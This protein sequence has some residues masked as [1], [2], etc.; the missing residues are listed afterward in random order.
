MTSRGNVTKRV[1]KVAMSVL[2][3]SMAA[4]TPSDFLHRL[5]TPERDARARRVLGMVVAGQVDS[6]IPRAQ[7]ETDSSQTAHAFFQLDSALRG[8]KVDSLTL[9]GATRF[10][11]GGAERLTLSYE[12]RTEKGWLAAGITTRDSAGTWALLGL[13]LNPLPGELRRVNDFNLAGSSPVRYLA[14]VLMA[15]CTIFTVGVAIFLATRRNF[16]KRWRWVLASLFGVGAVYVN[17]TTGEVAAKIFALQLFGAGVVRP[18]E[19][20]PWVVSFS[21]P[22]GAILAL[23]RYWRRRADL[24][25]LDA[26][27]AS[28][29]VPS[30][31]AA[32]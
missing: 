23:F 6:L 16:P 32:T 13:R 20:A 9:I 11:A 27:A 21:F 24:D 3:L 4:C 8:R 31:Q 7:F 1:L 18:S 30:G 14:L 5:A 10:D 12:F 26:P 25:A 28:D 17:W 19:F 29:D 2:A 22:L 15:A